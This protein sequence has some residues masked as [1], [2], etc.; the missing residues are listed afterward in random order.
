MW[1]PIS[2]T[3]IQMVIALFPTKTNLWF[4]VLVHHLVQWKEKLLSDY[5]LSGM[6]VTLLVKCAVYCKFQFL[7]IFLISLRF[8]GFNSIVTVSLTYVLLMCDCENLYGLLYLVCEIDCKMLYGLLGLLCEKCDSFFTKFSYKVFINWGT[9]FAR[10]RL[11]RQL[12][13]CLVYMPMSI[14]VHLFPY[15][16]CLWSIFLSFWYIYLL[17]ELFMKYYFFILVHLFSDAIAYRFHVRGLN[18][19][20]ASIHED[21]IGVPMFLLLCTKCSGQKFLANQAWVYFFHIFGCVWLFAALTSST[22]LK[23]WIH[24]VLMNLQDIGQ[25]GIEVAQR[26]HKATAFQVC[27]LNPAGWLILSTQWFVAVSMTVLC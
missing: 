6:N 7:P 14:L 22:R 9:C 11:S 12:P 17:I 18:I 8:L 26:E 1:L 4:C 10:T 5:P 3:C 24:L 21:G 16:I 20:M 23:Y 19:H 2:P 25:T 15:S 27:G 13:V